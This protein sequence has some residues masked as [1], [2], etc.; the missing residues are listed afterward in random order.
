MPELRKSCESKLGV[1]RGESLADDMEGCGEELV[2]SGAF[3]LDG[4]WLRER[5]E[6]I[7]PDEET[8]VA[9]SGGGPALNICR[10]GEK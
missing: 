6:I 4:G 1:V 8:P 3:A 9:I 5:D 2:L 7:W 10:C